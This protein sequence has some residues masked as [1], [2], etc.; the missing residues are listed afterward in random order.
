[1]TIRIQRSHN[2]ISLYFDAD[3]A[4]KIQTGTYDPPAGQLT[5]LTLMT[6]VAGTDHTPPFSTPHQPSPLYNS[7][8]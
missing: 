2:R 7:R 6:I 1:M 3:S 4:T 8:L 5:P